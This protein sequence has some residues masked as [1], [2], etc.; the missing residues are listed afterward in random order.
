MPSTYSPRIFAHRGSNKLAPENSKPAFDLALIEGADGF[1][2][3]LQFSRDNT[4]ILWHDDEMER[5]GMPGKTVKDFFLEELELLDISLIS[6]NFHRFCGMMTLEEFLKEYYGRTPLLLEIKEMIDCNE[7]AQ[8]ENIKVILKQL[9]ASS[10]KA[11]KVM[12]SS[13]ELPLLKMVNEFTSKNFTVANIEEKD[14]A[15]DLTTLLNEHSYL[16]GICLEKSLV[17]P[18]TIKTAKELGLT[19]LTYTCNTE[20]E[21]KPVLACEVDIIISDIPGECR[22][23]V[24]KLLSAR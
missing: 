9:K 8:E 20:E 5:I 15:E 4:A 1:E 23:T 19:T 6:K 13:F 10:V 14:I 17:N 22:K 3:D 24:N 11:D 2:T 16:K 12:I 21:L 18:Q 7:K